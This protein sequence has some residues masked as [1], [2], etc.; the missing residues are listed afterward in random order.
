MSAVLEAAVRF[1]REEVAPRAAEIDSDPAALRQAL[2]GMAGRGLL[3]LKRPA[4][5]GGP[6]LPEHEFREFQVQAARASGALAFLQTQHQSAVG[7]VAKG[8]NDGLKCRLLPRMADGSRLLGVGFSQLRRPGPPA[9]AAERTAGGYRLTGLAPWVTGHGYFPEFLVAGELP[10]GQAVFGLCPLEPSRS[11]RVSKPMRLAT[12]EVTA[13]VSVELASHFLADDDVVALRPKGWIRDN[14]MLN[15]VLQGYFAL[16]CALAG[17]DLVGE[18]AAARSNAV[19]RRAHA[20][21][22]AEAEGLR[23]QMD[24]FAGSSDT[25]AKLA[26]R[27][28]AIALAAQAA[29]VAVAAGGGRSLLAGSAA[30]RVSR[31][32]MVYTVSAQTT[33]I[34]EA[35]VLRLLAAGNVV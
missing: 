6:A 17:I 2:E 15:V 7:L 31:E 33:D 23:A 20:D 1:L 29:H 9:M 28:R 19:L 35:T 10:D 5:Y 12:F 25:P 22:S 14:D 3:A 34:L 30:Q 26:V 4:A 11:V 21:L 8:D 18:E 27:A 13:T 32:A 24:A 16:G